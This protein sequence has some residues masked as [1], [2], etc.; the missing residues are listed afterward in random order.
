M[1]FI[2]IVFHSKV[3]SVV[4]ITRCT[5]ISNQLTLRRKKKRKKNKKRKKACFDRTRQGFGPEQRAREKKGRRKRHRCMNY[6]MP[7]EINRTFPSYSAI[8]NFGKENENLV[9]SAAVAWLVEPKTSAPPSQTKIR[10]NTHNTGFGK[11]E[12]ERN[13]KAV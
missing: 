10:T 1:S 4:F 9:H 8:S 3:H 11:M 2:L 12:F 6:T 13:I 7:N 5:V